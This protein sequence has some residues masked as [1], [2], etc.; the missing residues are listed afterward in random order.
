MEAAFETSTQALITRDVP[1]YCT[2]LAEDAAGITIERAA[3]AAALPDSDSILFKLLIL[4]A[5][6]ASLQISLYSCSAHQIIHS[7]V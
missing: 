2:E 3:T 1:L 5:S 7:H 4:F 6:S